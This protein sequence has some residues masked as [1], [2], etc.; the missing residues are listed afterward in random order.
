MK[1]LSKILPVFTF[2]MAI[3]I[4]TAFSGDDDE[5]AWKFED[6]KLIK[7]KTLSGDCI[8]EKGETG[9]VSVNVVKGYNPRESCRTIV[10]EDGETLEIIEEITGTGSG[11]ST[12]WTLRVP[13]DIAVEFFSTSGG[14]TLSNVKGKFSGNSASGG[15]ELTSCEGEFAFTTA[16]GDYDI[17]N[18]KGM[19]EI[20][21][22]SGDIDAANIEIDANSA[23]ASASGSINV[24]VGETPEYDLNIGSASGNAVLDFD[25][26]PLL[27]HFEF[28]AKDRGGE[29]D[30]PFDFDD[31]ETFY[32]H[33]QRY[34]RKWFVKGPD[35]PEITIGT[36]SG[37]AVL[38]K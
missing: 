23:L 34:V 16:S 25:G 15:Y 10:R 27:G 21:S 4:L 17:E 5:T 14:M 12:I 32:K 6:I 9:E 33:D 38:R 30:S 20:S 26:N 2:A 19:F 35:E 37:R 11:R 3:L 18:C 36:S 8:I 24:K 31:E 13:D 28:E 22:A 1:Y 7:V 29:I